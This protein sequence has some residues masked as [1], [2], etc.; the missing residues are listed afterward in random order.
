MKIVFAGTPDF[1]VQPLEKLVESGADIVCVITQEDKPQGRK[2]L[3]TPP[4]VK[5]AAQRLG[6]PVLQPKKIRDEVETLK[7][8]GADVMITCAYGQILTQSVLD[9]FPKGVWNVHAGLLPKYRGAS[10]I[11]SCILAGETETGV[12]IMQTELGLDTGGVLVCKTTQI[13]DAETYGE[14]SSRLSSIG[15][16]ALLQ[17]LPL[18]ENAAAVPTP[19][20]TDGVQVVKKIAADAGKIDFSLPAQ[21]IINRV[22]AFNPSP[23]AYAFLGGVRV[24]IWCAQ[25]AELPEGTEGS[26]MGEVLTDKPK[27]GLVVRCGDGAVKILELQPAGGKKMTG[28]DFLNGRKAEKGQVFTC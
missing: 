7:S 4:P 9:V 24:N 25:K 20:Q 8:L 6:L 15:A 13:G 19:Q 21:E 3:L 10:P 28:G 1:A 27:Q 11:Q 18:I 5:V 17:A 23:A 16:D 12:C 2:N 14:L 26:K 22:R